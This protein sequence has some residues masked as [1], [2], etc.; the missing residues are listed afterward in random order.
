MDLK[1][2][3][4][5]LKSVGYTVTENTEIRITCFNIGNNYIIT[6][7]SN[8]YTVICQETTTDIRFKGVIEN[9]Q[10]LKGVLKLISR[11]SKLI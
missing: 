8:G 5:Y 4:T 7:L 6:Q 2:I 1:L 3:I 9:L 11:I 10:E